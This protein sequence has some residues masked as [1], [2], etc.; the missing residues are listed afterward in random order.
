MFKGVSANVARL[1]EVK[2]KELILQLRRLNQNLEK[3]ID[4]IESQQKN[5]E[6]PSKN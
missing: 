3:I 1:L 2:A 6:K 4:L 5:K